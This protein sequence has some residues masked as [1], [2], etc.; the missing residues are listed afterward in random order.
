MRR[1]ILQ[2]VSIACGV[3]AVFG[4]VKPG[5]MAPEFT[6]RDA[7][8]EVVDLSELR[9]K[10]VVLE[11]FNVGCPFVKKHYGSGNMQELQK[12]LTGQGVVWL[13]ILSSAPGKQGYLTPDEAVRNCSE[14]DS[15]ASFVILDTS[16]VIGRAYD[17]RCTPEMFLIAPDGTLIY[18]GAIDSISSVRKSD[19]AEAR[20]Y[21]WDAWVAHSGG[22]P[23]DPAITLPYGCAVKY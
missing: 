12:K 11:W 20:N 6:G 19:I 2:L 14:M 21:V 3:T 7:R 17:V 18:E 5:E 8:G 1:T 16:G 10:Y 9:G 13:S 15:H 23:V 4:A 22:K